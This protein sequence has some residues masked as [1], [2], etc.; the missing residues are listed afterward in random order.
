MTPETKIDTGM[1]KTIQ[2]MV[3]TALMAEVMKQPEVH[4]ALA[5]TA[6]AFVPVMLTAMEGIIKGVKR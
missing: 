1:Q 5:T 4:S 3:V 6:R 2:D